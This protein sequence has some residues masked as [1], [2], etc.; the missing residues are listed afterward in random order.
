[1]PDE[2]QGVKG[3]L[4]QD[5]RSFGVDTSTRGCHRYSVA[6]L[7][8]LGGL[9][10]VPVGNMEEVSRAA[11]HPLRAERDARRPLPGCLGQCPHRA[12]QHLVRKSI[13]IARHCCVL[14]LAE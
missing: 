14:V 10:A 1:M 4:V 2:R 13:P 7:L 6:F 3:L 8:A 11:G 9:P 5:G 12:A